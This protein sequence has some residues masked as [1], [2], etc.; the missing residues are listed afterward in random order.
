MIFIYFLV[1]L[2]YFGGRGGEGGGG[3]EGGIK[4]KIYKLVIK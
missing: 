2:P 1:L 4:I 3:G